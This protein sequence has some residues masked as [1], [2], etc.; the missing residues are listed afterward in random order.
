MNLL[1]FVT[2]IQST[3]SWEGE[4]AEEDMEKFVWEGSKSQESIQQILGSD[5]VEKNA[6]LVDEYKNTLG[7]L[8]NQGKILELLLHYIRVIFF[9]DCKL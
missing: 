7:S 3:E 2:S 1:S 6:Q 9:V 8:L 4:K 5:N